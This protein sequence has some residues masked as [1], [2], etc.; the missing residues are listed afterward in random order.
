M[1]FG[2]LI[3]D[4]NP[5]LL[6]H[7]IKLLFCRCFQNA[8]DDIGETPASRVTAYP[9]R[10]IMITGCKEIDVERKWTMSEE[11]MFS[12]DDIRVDL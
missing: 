7:R 2:N 11:Q 9:K 8:V 6:Y 12:N 4:Y 5:R 10:K 3:E 1:I